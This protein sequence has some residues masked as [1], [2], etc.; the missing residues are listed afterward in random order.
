MNEKEIELKNRLLKRL[1]ENP[2]L[3]DELKSRLESDDI[4]SGD[5]IIDTGAKGIDRAR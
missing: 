3:I 4:V 5:E 1:Q 2:D